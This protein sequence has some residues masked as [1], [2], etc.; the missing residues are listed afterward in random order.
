MPVSIDWQSPFFLIFPQWF[1]LHSFSLKMSPLNS[2]L[3]YPAPYLAYLFRMSNKLYK[4]N[5]SKARLLFISSRTFAPM[6]FL[7]WWKHGTAFCCS[8]YGFI[9]PSLLS[10]FHT[11][12]QLL[13]HIYSA[14]NIYLDADHF[15]F[16]LLCPPRSKPTS[17]LTCFCPWPPYSLFTM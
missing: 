11:P 4:S 14:F 2:R 3:S 7:S 6:L 10:L 16:S 17:S 5:V 8:D 1:T 13:N 9:E 15:T 12:A